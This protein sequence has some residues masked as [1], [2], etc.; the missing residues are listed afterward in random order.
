M[1]RVVRRRNNPPILLIVFVFL[2]VIAAALAVMMYIQGDEA[3]K[4]LVA[5]ISTKS[6]DGKTIKELKKFNAQMADEITG[7][8]GSTTKAAI[9]Q[10]KSTYETL[11]KSGHA[12]RDGLAPTI[13]R[14]DN[15]L[16]KQKELVSRRD[17]KNQ[18]LA[19]QLSD[20]EKMLK[21]QAD[22]YQAEIDKWVASDTK[23]RKDLAEVNKRRGDDRQESKKKHDGMLGSAQNEKAQLLDEQ[24]K[25][26]EQASRDKRKI[27]SL[28]KQVAD[29]KALLGGSKSEDEVFPAGKI[30]KITGDGI[31]YV[32]LGSKDKIKHGMT[33]S[34]YEKG[35]K[36]SEKTKGRLRVVKVD[37]DFS[38]CRI[39]EEN[40]TAPIAR[41]DVV[42]NVAY[43]SSRPPV[44]VIIGDYDLH[45]RGTSAQDATEELV[46][47]V[48]HFGAEVE[49]EVTY[50]TDF[51]VV[52]NEPVRPAKPSED[53]PPAVHKGYQRLKK[54]HDK[55]YAAKAEAKTMRIPILN[56]NRF[57]KL[58]GYTPEKAPE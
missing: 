35:E 3:E 1:A 49:N 57:L 15:I 24:E 40:K 38:V 33:F 30:I 29:L 12:E 13:L 4:N 50:R 42:A 14:L 21:A 19:V 5:G 25:M 44:F 22:K 46:S 16:K 52:G 11:K 47:A 9:T 20:R 55:Y 23:L 10:I 32:G 56:L 37:H 45:G 8:R 43:H 2:F 17:K 18:E 7:R 53:A 28:E 48:E 58:T 27:R 26:I 51:L 6:A 39:V 31:C 34:V 36:D 41:D 54:K